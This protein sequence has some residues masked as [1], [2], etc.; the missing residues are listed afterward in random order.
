V[1][2]GVLL[3]VVSIV[4]WYWPRGDARFV[5]KWSSQTSD[6]PSPG[7]IMVF[8]SNGTST[9]TFLLRP[10][11]KP[12]YTTWEVDGHYLRTGFRS[13]TDTNTTLISAQNWL[14]TFTPTRIHLGEDHWKIVSVSPD[15]IELVRDDSSLNPPMR[16][17]MRRIRE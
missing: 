3:F 11:A 1:I 7:A 14:N 2:A 8:R 5:G 10:G 4:W 13:F 16:Q 6:A 15:V 12:L 9:W 17:T